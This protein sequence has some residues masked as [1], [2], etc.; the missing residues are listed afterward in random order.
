MQTYKV[1]LHSSQVKFTG[2]CELEAM[3]KV[4]KYLLSYLKEKLSLRKLSGHVRYEVDRETYQKEIEAY[5]KLVKLD[6]CPRLLSHGI[7]FD[8]EIENVQD[9]L[10]KFTVHGYFMETEPWGIC[11]FEKYGLHSLSYP[12]HVKKQLRDL[13]NT[14]SHL[15]INLRNPNPHEI[16][17]KDEVIKLASFY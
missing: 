4:R 1:L 9:P 8:C 16:F 3:A 7:I 11:L 5:S 12:E 6:L 17:I 2:S 13:F 14:L 10:D 15:G